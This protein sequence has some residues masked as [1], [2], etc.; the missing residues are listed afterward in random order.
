MTGK[1]QKLHS[2][3]GPGNAEAKV[4]IATVGVVA[5]AIG[6]PAELGAVAPTPAALDTVGG[7][8]K[9]N[10]VFSRAFVIIIAVPVILAPFPYVSAHV[11]YP[12]FVRG[13]LSHFECF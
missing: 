13:L 7:T 8:V 4:V 5:A 11:V 2:I 12:Q 9:V 1:R 3:P 6:D 10:G